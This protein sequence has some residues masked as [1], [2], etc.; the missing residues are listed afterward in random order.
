M[1]TS[2]PKMFCF[3]VKSCKLKWIWGGEFV[4]RVVS[5][6]IQIYK[7]LPLVIQ[8]DIVRDLIDEIS[9]FY[10]R[11]ILTFG[12]FRCLRLCVCLSV[13]PCFN[14]ELVHAK[15][16]QLYKLESPNSDIRCKTP[17]LRSLLFWWVI[18]LDLQGQVYLKSQNLI[19]PGSSI[20][21][22]T[23]PS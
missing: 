8:I 4:R 9:I 7:S 13:C 12:Y 19:K 3:S 22:N 16:H 5:G 6:E 14:L 17:E 18:D 11:P 1:K 10:P 2:L 23:Q 21:V 20:R 15:T